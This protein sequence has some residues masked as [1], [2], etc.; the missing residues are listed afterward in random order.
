MIKLGVL[1]LV[2]KENSDL[3]EDLTGEKILGLCNCGVIGIVS[4]KIC[5]SG[6]PYRSGHP[7]KKTN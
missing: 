4:L 2:F 3:I 7:Q 6:S 1:L 5:S